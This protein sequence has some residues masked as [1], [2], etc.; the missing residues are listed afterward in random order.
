[1]KV[2]LAN[3]QVIANLTVNNETG[4][5]QGEKNG[6]TY[7]KPSANIEPKNGFIRLELDNEL[8]QGTKLEVEYEITVKNNSELDY[9]SEDFYKYG[10][11]LEN[12]ITM[13]PTGIVDYLDK[14]WSFDNKNGENNNWQVMQVDDDFKKL[15]IEEVY[16]NSGSSNT[17]I[18][19]KMILYT[20]Q[21]ER[22]KLEATQSKSITFNVSKI[23]TTTDEIAL[24]NEVEE[25]TATKTGGSMI[26]STLGNYVPGEGPTESDDSMAETTI[27]T[28]ATGENRDYILPIIIGATALI[29]L[30]AGVIIIKKKV[31]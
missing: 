13:T 19:Q 9:L 20:K 28:P 7:M 15:V 2:T 25:V 21:L 5:I 14:N 8:I 24:N 30:G 29:I 22:E 17:A 27:V 31:V 18:G 4:E 23:L 6:V 11:N 1:M 16:D 10:I 26:Q 3:G 12:P